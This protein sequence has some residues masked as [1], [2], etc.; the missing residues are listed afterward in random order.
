MSFLEDENGQSSVEYII[1]LAM[2]VSILIV[3]VRKALMPLTAKVVDRMQKQIN[4]RF[5]KGDGMHQFK[6]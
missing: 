1:L 5:L 4:D 6:L 3:F 2:I